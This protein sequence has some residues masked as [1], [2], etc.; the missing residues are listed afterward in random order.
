MNKQCYSSKCYIRSCINIKSKKT[1]DIQC[2]SNAIYG[3]YCSKHFKHPS[4]FILKREPLQYSKH[5]ENA[6]KKIQRFWRK[7]S[8]YIFLFNQ[9]PSRNMVNLSKNDTE[10]FSLEPVNSILKL[11]YF[12]IVDSKGNLWTF[13]IRSLAQMISLGVL[14]ENPYTRDTLSSK[15]ITKVLNRIE[16]LRSRGYTT[17]YISDSDLTSEQIWKQKILD[18]FTQ[19]ECFGFHVPYKWLIEMSVDNHIEFYKT[20]YNIWNYKLG[21]SYEQKNAIVPH[22]VELFNVNNTKK[23]SKNWWEKTN[24][25]HIKTLI[26]ST[27]DKELQRLGATYCMAAFVNVNKDAAEAYP[28]LN[29]L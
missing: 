3:D 8:P 11:Y 14:K 1:P 12:S 4:R 26:S 6:I 18:V 23:Y 13:D 7:M 5:E 15:I 10:I 29:D 2:K 9:G 16:W 24:L 28:W 27:S 20:L 22:S 25:Y 19:M 17:M 21:L